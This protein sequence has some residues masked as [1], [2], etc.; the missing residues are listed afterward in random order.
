[1]EK[2]W[3]P[4]VCPLRL[5][6]AV[7]IQEYPALGSRLIHPEPLHSLFSLVLVWILL[8]NNGYGVNIFLWGDMGKRSKPIA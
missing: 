6:I 2:N 3:S 7:N 1:M 8:K 4:Q 5:E